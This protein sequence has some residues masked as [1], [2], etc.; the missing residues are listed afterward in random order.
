MVD[1][2]ANVN[3]TEIILI[4]H[5]QSFNNRLYEYIRNLHGPNITDEFLVQEEIRLRQPDCILSDFGERQVKLLENYAA[6]GGLAKCLGKSSNDDLN[7]YILVSSPMKRCIMTS[8]ALINGLGK[9][10]IIKSNLYESGNI[11]VSFYSEL[12]SFRFPSI[13]WLLRPLR[14]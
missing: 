2:W 7:D 13:R 8:Q 1:A 6:S 3:I 9:D 10:C 11:E 12:S 14:S 4:R 5:A